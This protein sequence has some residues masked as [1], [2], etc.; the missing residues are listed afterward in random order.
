MPPLAI[1]IVGGGLAGLTLGI[2]LRQEGV[3]VTVW[4]A[5]HYPRHRVCGEVLSGE[6]F[7]ILGRLDLADAALNAGG[8]LGHTAAFFAS[9][10]SSR[11][12]KL[13]S[14]ALCI[15][16]YTLDA[17]LAARWSVADNPWP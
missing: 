1:H 17:L 13:L 9:G 15:D 2:R 11:L 14:P 3:P 6:G 4:E 5:G 12:M 10:K 16:R 8:Q 7:A